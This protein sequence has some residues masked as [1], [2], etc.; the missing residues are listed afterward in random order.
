MVRNQAATSLASELINKISS[1]HHPIISMT[2]RKR[3]HPTMVQVQVTKQPTWPPGDVPESWP[4]HTWKNGCPN[5]NH[6]NGKLHQTHLTTGESTGELR[7]ELPCFF[8]H[9]F[10]WDSENPKS[11]GKRNWMLFVRLAMWWVYNNINI[12]IYMYMLW[13]VN[14]QYS[15]LVWCIH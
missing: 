3:S 11:T 4:Q 8:C 9:F 10:V 14:P 7:T 1:L 5:R 13:I 6:H 15:S 12:Y 2:R